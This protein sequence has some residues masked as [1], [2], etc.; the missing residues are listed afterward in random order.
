METI[1]VSKVSFIHLLQKFNIKLFKMTP[2][3][4][5]LNQSDFM[6]RAKKSVITY[7]DASFRNLSSSIAIEDNHLTNANLE[8]VLDANVN[9]GKSEYIQNN[10]KLREYMNINQ[11]P[12]V[13]FKSIAYEKINDSINFVKG[14]LT[15]NNIT[16]VVELDAKIVELKNSN[17][18]SKVL[19]EIFGE[20]NRQDFGLIS[21]SN[22]EKDGFLTGYNLNVTAN[23]EFTK[24]H[25]N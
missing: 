8:F 2:T 20:I 10:V 16:K 5:N 23:L 17:N 3:Q 21:P 19:I 13:T 1:L 9:N 18:S 11:Y 25:I 14:Y 24:N 12:L 6:V 22:V 7:S 15:I 4:W